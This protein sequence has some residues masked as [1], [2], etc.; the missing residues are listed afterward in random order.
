ML[1]WENGGAKTS[2]EVG[3]N[4]AAWKVILLLIALEV[5]KSEG[6]RKE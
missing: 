6:E 1:F 5:G 3:R 2:Q 4:G